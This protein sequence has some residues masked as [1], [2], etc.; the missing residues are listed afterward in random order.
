MKKS[1]QCG[2]C[3]ST[4][5]Y[6]TTISSGGGHAPDLLPGVHP[7]YKSGKIEVY[8]CTRCGLTQLFAPQEVLSQV[9]KSK[10]FKRHSG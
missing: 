7:W 10:K 6:T 1:R 5:I 3:Q 9:P 4:T 8:I 2:E